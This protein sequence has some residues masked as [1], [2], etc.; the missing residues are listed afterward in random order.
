MPKQ[1]LVGSTVLAR[2]NDGC[3]VEAKVTRIEDSVAG[4]KVHIAFG[5]YAFKVEE[6]QIVKEMRGGH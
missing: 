2:L 5:P 4:R 1:I 6:K 3:E